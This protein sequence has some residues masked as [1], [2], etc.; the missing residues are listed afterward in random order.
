VTGTNSQD[1]FVEQD[2]KRKQDRN[3]EKKREQARAAKAAGPEAWGSLKAIGQ[4]A[5]GS[6]KIGE[7]L[8][9]AGFFIK[10]GDGYI[11]NDELIGETTLGHVRELRATP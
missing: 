10:S 4:A 6:R 9:R 3:W 8:V 7:S 1:E 2:R 11:P 5:G